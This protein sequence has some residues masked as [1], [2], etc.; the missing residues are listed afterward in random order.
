MDSKGR[1]KPFFVKIAPDLTVTQVN[2]VIDVVLDNGLTGIIATNTTSNDQ[3]KAKYGRSGEMGGISGADPDY[4][5]ISTEKIAY[6][7]RA[8]GN[9]LVIIGVGGVRDTATALEKIFAGATLLQVVTAI[10]FEGPSVA[11]KIN[12]GLVKYMEQE[13]INN[14]TELVGRHVDNTPPPSRT[15][16]FPSLSPTCTIFES[17]KQRNS[18]EEQNGD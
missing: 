18:V 13:G 8:V 10:G 6:I 4:R 12:R 1:R 9:D 7:R 11:G 5:R 15:Y 2:D 3:I 16:I 14:I 17:T